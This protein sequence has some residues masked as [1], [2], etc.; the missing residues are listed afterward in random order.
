MAAGRKLDGLEI[1]RALAALE[2]V[3]GHLFLF[4]LLPRQNLL[5]ALGQW[6]TEAVI[7]FFVLSGVVITSSV[8][9]DSDRTSSV[10]RY[11]T[12]R[13]CR[14]YP[15]FAF[16]IVL[17]FVVAILYNDKINIAQY[18]SSLLFAYSKTGYPFGE[19]SRDPPLW[20]LSN[21]ML[22]YALFI[23]SFYWRKFMASWTFIAIVVAMGIFP[24]VKSNSLSGYVSWMLAMSIP[25]LLGYWLV[26]LK[27]RLPRVPLR[28]GLAIFLIGLVYARCN[29]TG[30]YF[31]PF[32]LNAF[33]MCCATL[34]LAIVQGKSEV[35]S[36]YYLLRT[37]LGL[38]PIVILWI[39]RH[40]NLNTCVFLTV[41]DAFAMATPIR[42][43]DAN[44]SRWIPA[45]PLVFV[46]GV[47]YAIYA[48]HVPLIFIETKVIGQWSG[49]A[50]LLTFVIFTGL[51]AVVL[52][53][54][55][56]KIGSSVKRRMWFLR[57]REAVT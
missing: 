6:A 50:K 53:T 10:I 25:W 1:V 18:I 44:L 24:F 42:M 13:I 3:I 20:S 41:L 9:M 56:R 2:V 48:I 16:A 47:S 11:V 36:N 54:G 37:A 49:I 7:C 34:L 39:S 21:E 51:L 15:I 31:D 35:K 4:G 30:M 12:A 46:G 40:S 28:L 55:S 27:D 14:I 19:L 45:R 33:A 5:M 52:E 57:G 22:Y 17:S 32:R 29:M 38:P 26:T 43:K 8:T 23:G